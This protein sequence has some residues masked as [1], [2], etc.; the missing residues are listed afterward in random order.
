MTKETRGT[1]EGIAKDQMRE[2]E[3]LRRLE[4]EHELIGRRIGWLLTSQGLLL[5]AYGVTLDNCSAAA[6]ELQWWIKMV[7]FLVSIAVLFGVVAGVLAKWQTYQDFR[8][9]QRPP[10]GW[11]PWGVSTPATWIG[12]IPDFALPVIFAV[13]WCRLLR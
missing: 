2:T 13:V 5:A 11:P 3:Y 10:G 1:D 4:F 7:G 8:G 12:L 9:P 6:L